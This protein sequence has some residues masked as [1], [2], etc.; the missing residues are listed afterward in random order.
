[1]PLA[2]PVA[3]TAALFA[4]HELLRRCGPWPAVGLYLAAPVALIPV[5]A[6]ANDFDP[7]LWAKLL[8]IVFCACLG[9]ALRFT[10]LAER[11]GMRAAVTALIALNILEAAAVDALA[12]GT[13]NVLNACAGLALVAALPWATHPA[14]LAARGRCRDGRYELTRGWVL[15]YFAWNATFVCL[16]YPALAGH[17]LAVLAAATLAG[18]I[19]PGRWLQ[20]RAYTLAADLMALATFPGFFAKWPVA[21]NLNGSAAV[22]A[23]GVALVL[24]ARG[25]AGEAAS[26]AAGGRG[27]V[28]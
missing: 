27:T 25:A 26:R 14:R 1:M 19:D 2:E 5:W 17:H 7:F 13:A 11:P 15:G 22:A 6:R 10:R 18:L 24:A 23:A 8:T 21:V 4:L 3:L 28:R 12:G 20:A 16:N 9:T